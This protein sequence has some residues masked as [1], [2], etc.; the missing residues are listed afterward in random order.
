LIN[1]LRSVNPVNPVKS[2]IFGITNQPAEETT[3]RRLLSGA[4]V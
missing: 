4:M 2:Y 3:I 1:I